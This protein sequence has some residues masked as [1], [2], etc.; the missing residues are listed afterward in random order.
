[1]VDP[2]LAK[3]TSGPQSPPKATKR[4]ALALIFMVVAPLAI[5]GIILIAL[6]VSPKTHDGVS[7]ASR[8]TAS[9]IKS[10]NPPAPT[11]E[12]GAAMCELVY[13]SVGSGEVDRAAANRF[14]RAL[15]A[16]VGGKGPKPCEAF[17]APRCV[18][19]LQNIVD[20]CKRLS[21]YPPRERNSG[22][23]PPTS[24]SANGR[25]LTYTVSYLGV[26]SK[27]LTHVDLTMVGASDLEEVKG[28]F[29]TAKTVEGSGYDEYSTSRNREGV[30]GA[31][32]DIADSTDA[33]HV[34]FQQTMDEFLTFWE[35]RNT[36]H[37]TDGTAL[38]KRCAT[39]ATT[40]LNKIQAQ[41]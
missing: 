30:P 31:A 17:D 21:L 32:R 13:Q 6:V 29:L 8:S 38:L 14:A 26:V 37:I 34:L 22:D 23:K 11:S 36:A 19:A 3:P 28:A 7:D 20:Q 1:M 18:A 25:L 24:T 41:R 4:P 5:I 39:Q 40:L 2:T 12:D 9:N 10:E 15:G 35:D 16:M 33:V 27:Q